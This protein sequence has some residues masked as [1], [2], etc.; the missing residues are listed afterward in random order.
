ML[1]I[2][3]YALHC[4]TLYAKIPLME[5]PNYIKSL[6]NHW[7]KHTKI[8][9]R[10]EKIPINQLVFDQMV[11]FTNERLS[12][13]KK[14]T[15]GLTLPYTQDPI[16]S[17]YRF[18]NIYRELDRQTIE[19]HTLLK[20]LESNFS[21][22]LL[23]MLFCRSVCKPETIKKVGL[24][25]FDENNNKRV[26][27]NLFKLPSPKYGN[28]YVFPISLIQKNVRKLMLDLYLITFLKSI[29]L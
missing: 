14:K 5:L 15:K 8:R 17:Q 7:D 28:A 23:N 10:T 25:S 20:P 16:L 24:L 12:I 6:Y 18:C 26:Y 4:K 21:L 13:Y 9:S 3:V 29:F 27:E 1:G 22:W 2:R 19:F 11:S